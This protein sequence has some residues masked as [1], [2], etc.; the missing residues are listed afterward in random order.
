MSIDYKGASLC[1]KLN[2]LTV[3]TIVGLC[4]LVVIVLMG[5][6]GQLLADRKNKIRNL[7]EVAQA[8]IRAS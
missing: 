3:I 2:G 8:T 5:E 7:V 6:K 4:I 1:T